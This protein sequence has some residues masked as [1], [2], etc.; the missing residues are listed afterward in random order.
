MLIL[1]LDQ[2][3][4]SIT[5][6]TQKVASD[7]LLFDI[8]SFDGK[9]LAVASYYDFLVCLWMADHKIHI[10]RKLKVK[11]FISKP[12]KKLIF[13]QEQAFMVLKFASVNPKVS[14]T[15]NVPGVFLMLMQD[16]VG[17]DIESNGSLETRFLLKYNIKF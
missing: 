6:W 13:I 1:I 17:I 11:C 5:K 8:C 3:D 9:T 2:Q 16:G 4:Y 10:S 15:V 7:S 12:K 14:I